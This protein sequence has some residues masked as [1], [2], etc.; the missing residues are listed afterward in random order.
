L[1]SDELKKFEKLSSLV[2]KGVMKTLT[3]EFFEE[4]KDNLGRVYREPI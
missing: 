2:G 4:K 3:M 1:T